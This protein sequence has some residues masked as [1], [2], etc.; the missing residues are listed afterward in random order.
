MATLTSAEEL[1][2]LRAEL[3]NTQRDLKQAKD[4]VAA[5]NKLTLK[6]SVR[7][8]NTDGSIKTKG[9][10]LMLRGLQRWPIT[11]YKNQWVRMAKFMP[12]ILAFIEEHDAELPDKAQSQENQNG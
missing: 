3:A 7:A 4:A 8:L 11:L 12:E 6:V 2:S 5:K 1:A 10:G 9:G